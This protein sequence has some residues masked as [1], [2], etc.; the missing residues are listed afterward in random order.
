MIHRSLFHPFVASLAP[1]NL[2]QPTLNL[3]WGRSEPGMQKEEH[4]LRVAVAAT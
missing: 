2:V 3:S 1:A 4:D